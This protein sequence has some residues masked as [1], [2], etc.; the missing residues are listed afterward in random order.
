MSSTRFHY[1]LHQPGYSHVM[2]LG[3]PKKWPMLF[4]YGSCTSYLQGKGLLCQYFH[5]KPVYILLPQCSLGCINWSTPRRDLTWETASNRL[6][7]PQWGLNTPHHQWPLTKNHTPSFSSLDLCEGFEQV[8]LNPQTAHKIGFGIYQFLR[9]PFG[10]KSSCAFTMAM[11]HVHI[12]L[13]F[14][15]A[16]I[17]W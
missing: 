11:N 4:S 5:S 17:C 14:N 2:H 9:S 12:G 8:A 6:L 15:F 1:L 3:H 10:L 7:C 13:T 16:V